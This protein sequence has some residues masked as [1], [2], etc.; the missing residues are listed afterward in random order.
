MPEF[1]KPGHY[2]SCKFKVEMKDFAYYSRNGI[3]TT[4]PIAT[5]KQWMTQHQYDLEHG[6]D[7][8]TPSAPAIPK[9]NG[10]Q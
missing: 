2:S 1:G 9:P 8:P 7:T 3:L 5:D 10:T 4:E 6:K